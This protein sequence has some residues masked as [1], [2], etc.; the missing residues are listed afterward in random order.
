MAAT[1]SRN[2]V[3]LCAALHN[4]LIAHVAFYSPNASLELALVKRVANQLPQFMRLPNVKKKPIYHF[5]SLIKTFTAASN[6]T[7]LTPFALQPDIN[8]L[9]LGPSSNYDHFT[10]NGFPTVIRLY[11]GCRGTKTQG[12]LL[13]VRTGLAHWDTG[14]PLPPN[15]EVNWPP[16]ERILQTWIDQWDDGKFYWDNGAKMRSWTK[17]DLRFSLD[18]WDSLLEEIESR[19]AEGCTADSESDCRF[20]I[21]SHITSE[22]SLNYRI[23]KAAHA[24]L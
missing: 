23:S 16:L 11:A 2:S 12:L 17:S 4:Q 5:L 7:S 14:G 13:D 19:I 10:V 24:F 20:I 15:D 21:F 1:F 18:A 22:P 9:L 6:L 8:Y 3:E